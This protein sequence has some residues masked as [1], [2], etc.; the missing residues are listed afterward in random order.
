VGGV[1]QVLISD[2]WLPNGPQI[3]LSRTM[4]ASRTSPFKVRLFGNLDLMEPSLT[5]IWARADSR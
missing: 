4:G 3:I 5:G 1:A 2:A